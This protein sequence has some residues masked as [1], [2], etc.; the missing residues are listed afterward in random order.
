MGAD[1][2]IARTLKT[3]KEPSMSIHYNQ[4]GGRIEMINRHGLDRSLVYDASECK[5]PSADSG[6]RKG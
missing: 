1:Y 5:A 4:A 6:Q 3:L 2:P